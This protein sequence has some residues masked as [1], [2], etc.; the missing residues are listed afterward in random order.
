MLQRY[1]GIMNERHRRSIRLQGADYQAGAYFVTICTHERQCLFGTI[2]S[3]VMSLNTWGTIV[4]ECFQAIPTHFSQVRVD[5]FVVM[6]NHVHGM[7]VIHE[8][9][10]AQHAAPL[11]PSSPHV[12]SGSL[13]AIVRSFKSATTK[14]INLLRETPG[15]V[16][17]QRNYHEHIIRDQTDENRIRGYIVANPQLWKQDSLWSED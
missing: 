2:T 10:R 12:V 6:P 3:E 16:L 13:G 9:I 7:I 15:A 1:G 17:W 5:A 8:S 14:R 4:S 11:H